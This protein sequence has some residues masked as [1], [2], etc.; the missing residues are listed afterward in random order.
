MKQSNNFRLF[1][2][3]IHPVYS[4]QQLPLPTPV[5]KQDFP[6]FVTNFSRYYKLAGE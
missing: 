4:Q 1:F 6:L 3:H 5:K 2:S